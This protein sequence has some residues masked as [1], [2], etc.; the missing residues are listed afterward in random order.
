MMAPSLQIILA[1]DAWFWDQRMPFE[2]FE[3]LETPSA[4]ASVVAIAG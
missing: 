1:D 3:P 4:E 2:L